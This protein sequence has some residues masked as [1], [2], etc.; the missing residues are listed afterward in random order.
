MIFFLKKV[1]INIQLDRVYIL[2]T[3]LLLLL[4]I[5]SFYLYYFHELTIILFSYIQIKIIKFLY[6][7]SSFFLLK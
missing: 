2:L 4:L 1:S 5:L 3:L 7:I 6:N